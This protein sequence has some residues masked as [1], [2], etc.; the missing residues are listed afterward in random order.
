MK[1]S[2][3]LFLTIVTLYACSTKSKES[4][5]TSIKI[6]H[7][8]L[9]RETMFRI[10]SQSFDQ[11]FK[12]APERTLTSKPEIDSLMDEL[13]IMPNIDNDNT[14][15]VRCKIYINHA[16]KKTD[17]ILLDRMVLKYKGS[18]Y[19]TPKSLIRMIEK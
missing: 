4:P 17:T 13:Y 3:C 8:E 10:N 7:T 11:Y 6:K 19:E 9:D 2:I 16:N 1:Y 14:P 5:V 15:D 12:N 18:T